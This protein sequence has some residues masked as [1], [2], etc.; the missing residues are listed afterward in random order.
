MATDDWLIAAHVTDRLCCI[1]FT[2]VM[3]LV[4]FAFVTVA[5]ALSAIAAAE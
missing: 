4:L 1:L 5:T 2:T 3:L